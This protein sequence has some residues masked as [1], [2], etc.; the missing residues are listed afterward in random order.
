MRTVRLARVAAEAELLRLRRMSRR[1]AVDAALAL[2]ALL[3]VV[4]AFALGHV[5]V[6]LLLQPTQGQLDAVLYLIGG[7]MA[8]AV[9]FGAAVAINGPGRIEREALE[10]RQTARAQIAADLTVTGL[11]LGTTRAI[12]SRRLVDLVTAVVRVFLKRSK[13]A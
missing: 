4:A 7:D 8:A 1:L 6:F 3:F 2:V 13:G 12:G 11:V 10:V 5:A 9:L